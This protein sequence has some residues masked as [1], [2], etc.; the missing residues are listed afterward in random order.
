VTGSVGGDDRGP[1]FAGLLPPAFERHVWIL[2][3]GS[4]RPVGESTFRDALV[5]VEQGEIELRFGSGHRLRFGHGEVL[6]LHG[7]PRGV[8]LSRGP[9]PAVLVAVRRRPR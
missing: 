8:L 7:L 5:E 2:P 4:T 3:V 1:L 6:W 9:R